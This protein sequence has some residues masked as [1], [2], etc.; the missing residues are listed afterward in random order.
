MVVLTYQ[1]PVLPDTLADYVMDEEDLYPDSL[2]PGSMHRSNLTAYAIN[3]WIMGKQPDGATDTPLHYRATPS[4]DTFHLPYQLQPDCLISL[5][6]DQ[7]R[8]SSTSAG[9]QASNQVTLVLANSLCFSPTLSLDPSLPA[10]NDL[11]NTVEPSR[12]FSS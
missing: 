10:E 1:Q 4:A 7:N 3:D 11:E 8:R 2:Q 5:Q 6:A 12:N 9:W